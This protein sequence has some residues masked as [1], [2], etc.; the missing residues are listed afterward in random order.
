MGWRRREWPP[1]HLRAR[2]FATAPEVVLEP[3]EAGEGRGESIGICNG[4]YS[5]RIYKK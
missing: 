4:I 5:T 1:L 2:L 3:G